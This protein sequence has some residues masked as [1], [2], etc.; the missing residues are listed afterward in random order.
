MN[1]TKPTRATRT[2]PGTKK[3]LKFMWLE[4]FSNYDELYSVHIFTKV[5]A[6]GADALLLC[7]G[8][9]FG[10][11]EPGEDY[12]AIDRWANQNHWVTKI[13][14]EWKMIGGATHQAAKKGSKMELHP[15]F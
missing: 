12:Q 6:H 3:Q 8:G 4:I 5:D 7:T 1:A 15:L 14:G 2:P 9:L 10:I 13:D 11:A